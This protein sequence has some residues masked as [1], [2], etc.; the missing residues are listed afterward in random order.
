M[1]AAVGSNTTTLDTL[2]VRS[3]CV[4]VKLLQALMRRNRLFLPILVGISITVATF[5]SLLQ[6]FGDF[7]LHLLSLML[8]TSVLVCLCVDLEYLKE[9]RSMIPISNQRRSDLYRTEAVHEPS[10]AL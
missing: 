3:V 2:T 8:C 1:I 9:V 10:T 5:P 7:M 4:G 6:L